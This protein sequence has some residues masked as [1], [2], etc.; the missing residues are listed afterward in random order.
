MFF[1]AASGLFI[2]NSLDYPRQ[3][4]VYFRAIASAPG[5]PDSISNTVPE[6]DCP[7]T[8]PPG[9]NL[10]SSTPRLPPTSLFLIGNGSKSDLDFDAIQTTAPNGV[11]L[12]IQSTTNPDD[13]FSWTDLNDG[14]SGHMQRSTNPEYPDDFILLA[15]NLPSAHGIYYRALANLSGYVDSISN[16]MGP[17]DLT[18]VVPPNVVIQPPAGLPGSGD[19]HDICHPVLV[20]PG[21]FHFGAT[22]Q[23]N[24]SIRILKLKVNGSTV[25]QFNGQTGAVDY[26][27]SRLG[28]YLLEGFAIDD[29]NATSRGDRPPECNGNAY[30]HGPLYV[31][32]VPAAADRP[33]TPKTPGHVYYAVQNGYWDDLSTWSDQNGNPVTTV[34]GPDDLAVI[35]SKRVNISRSITVGSLSMIAAEIENLTAS[36]FNFEVLGNLLLT[37]PPT[38]T[39]PPVFFAGSIDIYISDKF[40]LLNSSDAEVPPG[41]SIHNLG[42]ITLRGAAGLRGAG[43]LT[44]GGKISFGLPISGATDAATNPA[45]GMQM[46]EI[47]NLTKSGGL[48]T[49]DGSS[50]IGHDGA[51]LIGHDGASVVSAGGG[52]VVSA[53]GGNLIGHDGASLIGHDGASLIGH[54]GASIVRVGTSG[55]NHP[56]SSKTIAGSGAFTQTGGETQLNSINIIG[57]VT[58]NGGALNGTG[59]IQGDLTNNGGTIA[60][61][62]SAGI[63]GVTGNFTQGAN[64]KL[65][66]DDG[67]R[68]PSQFDQLQVAG[69]ANLGGNLTVHLSNGYM[70][71]VQDTFSSLAYNSVNG[72]FDSVSANT[73]VML[74]PNGLLMN[75][76]PSIPITPATPTASAATNISGYSFAANWITVDGATGYRLDVSTDPSF[77]SYVPSYQNRNA[78]NVVSY[79]VK[80]LHP[81]TTYYYRVRAYN[82]AG[83]S[84]NSNSITVATLQVPPTPTP[85][86]KPRPTPGITPTPTPRPSSTPK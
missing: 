60:P 81:N 49:S 45:A 52:N 70:P 24:R 76:D 62:H 9:L 13:E 4:N 23:T 36:Q 21:S 75:V 28:D 73:Q 82:S 39:N 29:L 59:I 30:T 67:G 5:Y 63:I 53:G 57:P 22:A 37:G 41:V 51:S 40:L 58:L 68:F 25:D 20:A 34:P 27:T 3:N 6:T 14:Q 12:R 84:D 35:D 69:S 19:G 80:G 47:A 71:D 15:N 79:V 10:A 46:I 31:R 66:V 74:T 55:A 11:A 83:T 38:F 32:V 86:P 42:D 77:A 72:N 54:D 64:G 44:T 18:Q 33:G 56:R 85:T 16:V 48:L 50:L 26:T 78:G 7:N 65:V 17:L 8:P 1:D 2:L 43:E 61:G